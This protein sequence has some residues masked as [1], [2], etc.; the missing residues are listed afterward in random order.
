ME[1]LADSAVLEEARRSAETALSVQRL[2]TIATVFIPL[3]FVCS[4]WGMTFEVF[5]TGSQPLWKLF[6]S[7]VPVVGFALVIYY[8]DGLGR[9]REQ[10]FWRLRR[11]K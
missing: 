1:T 10:E 5:G 6:V 7:A 9:V 2:T 11:W 8:W 3:S 4:I